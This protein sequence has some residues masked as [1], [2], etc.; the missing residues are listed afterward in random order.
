MFQ[1]VL[2]RY[3]QFCNDC[4][5]STSDDNTD[6]EIGDDQL[7]FYSLSKTVLFKRPDRRDGVYEPLNLYPLTLKNKRL[8]FIT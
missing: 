6:D 8:A 5:I 3:L 4:L 1:D 2:R 7:V